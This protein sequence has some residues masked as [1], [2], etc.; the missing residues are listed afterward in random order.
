M[1]KFI[2]HLQQEAGGQQLCPYPT[3]STKNGDWHGVLPLPGGSSENPGG[4]PKSSKKVKKEAA[5][6]GSLCTEIW[7]KL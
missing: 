7:R 1:K 5:S 4:L 2:V 3:G 6:K